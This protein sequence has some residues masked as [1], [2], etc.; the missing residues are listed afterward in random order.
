M[1]VLKMSKYTQFVTGHNT[2][3][4]HESGY[5][6]GVQIFSVTGHNTITLHESGYNMGVQIF[7]DLDV[8]A[9]IF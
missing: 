8:G 1:L 4:L 5:N 3:T 7:S 2:I 6:M 9:C